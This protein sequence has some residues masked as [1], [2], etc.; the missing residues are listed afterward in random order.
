MCSVDSV[1]RAEVSR[2]R[3]LVRARRVVESE[4]SAVMVQAFF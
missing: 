1:R 3:R 4:G 2:L